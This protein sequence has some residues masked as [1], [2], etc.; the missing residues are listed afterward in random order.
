M[1]TPDSLDA[2]KV[3]VEQERLE[4]QNEDLNARFKEMI[5]NTIEEVIQSKDRREEE[6]R[7]RKE[8]E[9]IK[10]RIQPDVDHQQDAKSA[11]EALEQLR[12]S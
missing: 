5:T 1:F 8:L 3:H 10:E 4:L 11:N 12:S 7:L 2:S 6:E 9:E